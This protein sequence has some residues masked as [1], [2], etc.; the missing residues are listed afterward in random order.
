MGR[1][2]LVPPKDSFANVGRASSTYGGLL[3][4][5]APEPIVVEPIPEEE[6]EEESPMP[7]KF[8]VLLSEKQAMRAP[9]K[10]PDRCLPATRKDR[11]KHFM[12]IP[13]IREKGLKKYF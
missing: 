1:E 3:L 11:T 2:T 13:H 6:S 9:V 7:S 5:S 4:P 10:L 12:H 8:P